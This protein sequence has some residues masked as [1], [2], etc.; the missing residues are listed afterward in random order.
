[1]LPTASSKDGSGSIHS[2]QSSIPP[3]PQTPNT[4]RGSADRGYLGHKK[5]KSSVDSS[6]INNDRMSFFGGTLGRNRKP[7]PRYPS[8]ASTA[9]GLDDPNSSPGGVEKQK[10]LTRLVGGPNRLSKSSTPAP[11]TA[12]V[13]GNQRISVGN[14][15]PA[16]Q[17]SSPLR[18]SASEGTALNKIGKPDFAGYMKKK[19]ERYNSWKQRYFV[20]KGAHL[21]YLKGPN[22]SCSSSFRC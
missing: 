21:Y 12:P 7:A 3:S 19:G 20:L 8:Y 13:Q 1:M 2:A 17:P 11:A 9:Y 5:A 22:V 6:K 14:P 10:S 16:T 18:A 15:I 4:K